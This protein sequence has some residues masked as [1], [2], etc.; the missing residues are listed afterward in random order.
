MKFKKKGKLNVKRKEKENHN[1]IEIS[2]LESRFNPN[3]I[4]L[5]HCKLNSKL[6]SYIFMDVDV[7]DAQNSCCLQ[8][9]LN[10]RSTLSTRGIYNI[11][12]GVTEVGF[13]F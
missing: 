7:R 3:I 8:V 12:C 11:L 6:S 10:V 2:R 1:K 13:F 5:G 9:Y 4:L